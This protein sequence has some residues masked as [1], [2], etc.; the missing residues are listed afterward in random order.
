MVALIV[1]DRQAISC[2]WRVG[3]RS[4]QPNVSGLV[5]WLRAGGRWEVGRYHWEVENGLR[6]SGV[7]LTCGRVRCSKDGQ[8]VGVQAPTGWRNLGERGSAMVSRS[9]VLGVLLVP[10]LVPAVS[11][12]AQPSAARPVEQPTA[13]AGYAARGR[14]A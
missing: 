2:R 11:A 9:L 6:G 13:V 1:D 7:R 4:R 10:G 12:S 3:M 14:G 8:G 5:G